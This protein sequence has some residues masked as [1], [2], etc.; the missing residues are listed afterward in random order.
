MPFG[1][2]LAPH[3]R[4]FAGFFLHAAA[5][6][7][8][9]PRMADIKQQMGVGEQTLGFSLIGVPAGTL[10]ALTFATP[11]IERIGFRRTLLSAIPLA[12][13]GYALAV[14]A[15][16]PALFFLVLMPIGFLIGC[17]EI[18]LNTEA[19]RVEH[20]LNRRIMNRAHSFWSF[21]FFGAGLVGAGL[22]QLGLSPQLDL[23]LIAPAILLGVALLLGKFEA[24]PSRVAENHHA[25]PTLSLPSMAI[26]TLVMVTSSAMLM[27]GAGIDWSAI[28]MRNSFNSGP[29]M[30]GVAVAAVTLSQAVIRFFADSYVEKHSPAS[31][32][33]VLSV[34][35]LAGTIVTLLA[36]SPVVSLIGFALI[37]VGC[38]VMFPLS[39]SA[40][41]QRTDRPSAINVASMAQTS[42]MIFL[43]GPPLLGTLGQHFGTP[44]IYGIG[45]PLAVLS[46]FTASALG[47]HKKSAA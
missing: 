20:Q 14:H 44:W 5:M 22:A 15:L 37:G 16:I 35:L 31:V 19:D 26:L 27:E 23:A 39:M 38:S 11:L 17:V 1:L 24:A 45:A 25:R 6:G 32:S 8:I 41:A 43:L 9:F 21:G 2:T 28:Y 30:A 33:R 10:L 36:I 3:H 40:A 18:V 34:V 4:V 46:L 7:S 12:A 47:T 29:F 13:M 42:F